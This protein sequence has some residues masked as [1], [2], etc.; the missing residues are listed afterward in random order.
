MGPGEVISGVKKRIISREVITLLVT[1]RGPPR[2]VTWALK[3]QTKPPPF[4]L[5]EEKTFQ[6]DNLNVSQVA[7][8]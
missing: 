3:L 1:V 7:H 2:S 8:V 4:F 6:V 5:S